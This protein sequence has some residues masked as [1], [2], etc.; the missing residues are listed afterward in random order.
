[1]HNFSQAI[2]S[3]YTVKLLLSR[4]ADPAVAN[5]YSATAIHYAVTLR[6]EFLDA[7]LSAL[8]PGAA[9]ALN[10]TDKDGSTPLHWLVESP[11]EHSAANL[12]RVLSMPG[13]LHGIVHVADCDLLRL[14]SLL[15]LSL[16]SEQA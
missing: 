2:N 15:G 1:M 11:N 10:A 13:A 9:A 16:V 3:K 8:G 14:R 7:L 12:T 4:G 5:D 6:P